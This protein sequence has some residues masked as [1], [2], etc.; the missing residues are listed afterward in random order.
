MPAHCFVPVRDGD[1]IPQ[2][3]LPA[4]FDARSAGM[5]VHVED[6]IRQTGATWLMLT[7]ASDDREVADHVRGL[8]ALDRVLDL[9]FE[10]IEWNVPQPKRL[11]RRVDHA[12][13]APLQ[14]AP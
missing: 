5:D 3:S 9:P 12:A 6:G 10:T 4:Y 2:I 14:S 11:Y 13:S 1:T 8:Y 7:E